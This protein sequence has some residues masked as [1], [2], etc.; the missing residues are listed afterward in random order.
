MTSQYRLACELMHVPG[1]L[2]WA[3]NSPAENRTAFITALF[4]NIPEKHRTIVVDAFE[5][6]KGTTADWHKDGLIFETDRL[7]AEADGAAL[8]VTVWDEEGDQ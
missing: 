4:A 6:F 2:A 1:C 5:A 7:A 3:S 8:L